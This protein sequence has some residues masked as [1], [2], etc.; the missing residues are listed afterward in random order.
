MTITILAVGKLR[1]A[2]YRAGV[3]DYLKRIK[4]YLPTEQI[5]VLPGT[6]E[7]CNGGGRGAIAREA[8]TLGK[9]LGKD[10]RVVALDRAGRQLSTEEFAKWFQECMNSAVPSVTFVV[11][12][13]WGLDAE[14][15]HKADLALSLSAFTLPH[16]LARLVMVEQIYRALSLWKGH[17]Y[18]K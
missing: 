3:E 2:Y 8:A 5:E 17:P 12:G 9:H 18:H 11:G 10:G 15:V 14:I 1:E 4:R 6:G 7:E 16:E 13:A